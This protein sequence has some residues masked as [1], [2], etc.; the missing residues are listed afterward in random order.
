MAHNS[1]PYIDGNR[2]QVSR[3]VNGT[4]SNIDPHT[5][6]VALHDE[7]VTVAG[8]SKYL[9]VEN[10]RCISGSN[11]FSISV[12]TNYLD[13]PVFSTSL[14]K[15]LTMKVVSTGVTLTDFVISFGVNRTAGW[16]EIANSDYQYTTGQGENSANSLVFVRKCSP[17]N[18]RTLTSGGSTWMLLNVEPYNEFFVRV[19]AATAGTLT[20]YTYGVLL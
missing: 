7:Y 11:A 8:G 17:V 4:G 18:P 16:D 1:S 20:F 3:T 14:L 10:R 12:G 5:S 13:N 2:G 9:S 19:V 15:L 6:V